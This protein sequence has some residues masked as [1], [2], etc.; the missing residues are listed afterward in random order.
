MGGNIRVGNL[1]G[2]PFYINPSWFFVLGLVTLSY[3]G[4]LGAQFPSLGAITPW[5][6]GLVAALLLF[7][8]VLAHE[9]GHSFVAI[10]QG[11][12]VKSITLFLFGGLAA[13]EKESESPGEAFWVAIAG[14]AVSVLLF[15]LFT[16]VNFALPLSGPL[17]AVL[18][19]LASVNLILAL[20]N[21]IPGL[22]LD[23]GNILKAAVWKI[24][25]NPYKGVVFASRAGQFLGW[26]AIISG[27]IPLFL[28]GSFG[29]FWN[30]LIGWFLL[31]NAGRSAQSAN[32]QQLLSGLKAED[33]V[34]PDSPVVSADIS[35]REF[36]NNYIIGK[37]KWARFLVTDE[38]GQLIGAI[39]VDEL[40]NIPT[41]H[42]T[43]VSVKELMQP[44]E[45]STTVKSDQS[46]LEVV[47]LLEQKKLNQLPVIRDN[48]VLVGLLEKTS[49][50][51]LLQKRAQANPA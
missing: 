43:E 7:A 9:L 25:G 5:L 8:S 46:L 20:F 40:R 47:T 27:L 45:L 15:G 11:I 42:W 48:G 28:Y 44:T 16:A 4:A 38:E 19:L 31:Q 50:M 17:G 35:L 2:I 22:P 26:L 13:L 21:L 1:F 41:S 37:T 6:L 24:T 10:K 18:G 30:I 23:G 34:L 33:A 39:P 36:A 32:I 51:Q 12:G 3:G 49:V 29:N 14:P